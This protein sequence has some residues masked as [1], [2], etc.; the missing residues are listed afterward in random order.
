[1][2]LAKIDSKLYYDKMQTELEKGF[3]KD[4]VIAD[5]QAKLLEK[6]GKT[7]E[8]LLRTPPLVESSSSLPP[9]PIQPPADQRTS[10]DKSLT[11]IKDFFEDR[12]R[13]EIS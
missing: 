6:D 12:D 8:P 10:A 11:Q 3:D 13:S 9:A 5:L 1:M 7:S 2:Q 4:K